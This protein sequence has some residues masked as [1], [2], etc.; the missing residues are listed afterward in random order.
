MSVKY[1]SK[2][3]KKLLLLTFVA[4]AL[5]ARAYTITNFDSTIDTNW[6]TIVIPKLNANYGTFVAWL[7]SHNA[8][9]SWVTN[10]ILFHQ[11]EIGTNAA[12][13]AALQTNLPPFYRAGIT[14][15]PTL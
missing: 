4:L 7:N 12:A 6:A 3:M 1:V 10:Q 14:N 15:I 13:I 5:N 2:I 8:T 9:N 11:L